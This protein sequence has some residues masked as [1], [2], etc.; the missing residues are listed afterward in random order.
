M[1]TAPTTA[2]GQRLVRQLRSALPEHIGA[3]NI[4]TII[5]IIRGTEMRFMEARIM[6]ERIMEVRITDGIQADC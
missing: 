6:E 4:T 1:A 3:V 5:T 2:R